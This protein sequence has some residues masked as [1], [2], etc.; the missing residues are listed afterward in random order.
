MATKTETTYQIARQICNIIVYV[1]LVVIT[2]CACTLPFNNNYFMDIVSK[3]NPAIMPAAYAVYVLGIAIYVFLLCFVVYQA[4]SH[5]KH[6]RV[7]RSIDFLFWVLV[8]AEIVWTFGF[9][10]DVQSLAFVGMVIAAVAAFCI[11]NRVGIGRE[12]VT[13]TAYW[14]VHFP[15]SLIAACT[16]FKIVSQVSIFCIRYNLIWWGMGET[17]WA[18]AALLLILFFGSLFLQYRPDAGFGCAMVWLSASVA[19]YQNGQNMIVTSFAY[20]LVLYFGLVT[21]SNSMHRPRVAKRDTK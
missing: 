2:V 14:C 16:L 17:A 18:I 3:Y 9:F 4:M 13:N 8:V 12:K 15:F 20:L 10:Y 21:F 7:I 6:D 1:A 19:V 5:R 11:Y